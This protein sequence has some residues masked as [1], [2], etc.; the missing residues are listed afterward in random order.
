MYASTRHLDETF[1]VHLSFGAHDRVP[2]V[3]IEVPKVALI[4]IV[5]AVLEG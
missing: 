5:A 2:T 3:L 1:E 4:S